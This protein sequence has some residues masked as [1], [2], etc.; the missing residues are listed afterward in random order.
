M[1]LYTASLLLA[2]IGVLAAFGQAQFAEKDVI[3]TYQCSYCLATVDNYLAN[4]FEGKSLWKSCRALFPDNLCQ[5]MGFADAAL[6]TTTQVNA[7]SRDYCRVMEKCPANSLPVNP[8]VLSD[9]GVDIR[10]SKAMGSRG[11]NKVRVSAIANSTISSSYFSYQS[12]FK[13]R[14]TDKYLSTGIVTV[15]PGVKTQISIAGNTVDLFVPKDG[16]GVRGVII[17]D[18][19]F[20]SEW[21]VC[22]YQT[23]FSMFQRS[24]EILNAIFSHDDTH[25]W[26]ILGDNFYDQQ[27]AASSSWFQALSSATKSRIFATVPGNHDFWVNASPTLWVPKDQQGNG[28]MQFYGQD[29]LASMSSSTPYDF[30]NNPDGANKGAENLPPASNFFFYN[31]VGNVAFIGYSGAHSFSTME[32]SFTEA[33]TWAQSANPDSLLLLGHWNSD[34]DGCDADA[35]VPA[36]YKSILALP[37]CAPLASKVRYFMGHKHC[38]IVTQKDVGFMVGGQGMSDAT[39]CGGAYGIPI[40]DTTGGRFRVYYFPI[41]QANTFDNYNTILSCI[42]SK[43]VSGCYN[44]AQEWAN[45]PL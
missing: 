39:S 26:Q 32:K 44:L 7:D 16:E 15:T 23:K 1:M 28:F 24:T 25:Y 9:N 27:G 19:C 43:G 40:V 2:I 18:P 11:Y 22:I 12:Q 29:V 8:P 20:Q 34:G 31:K 4:T 30:S 10:V 36:V 5:G 45:V 6:P 37:A 14:W 13:Y 33:C 41:A 3:P 38:N 35:T 21:I 42:Q 17:A